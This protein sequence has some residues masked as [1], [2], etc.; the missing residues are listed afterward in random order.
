MQIKCSNSPCNNI[1]K[2]NKWEYNNKYLFGIVACS[3]CRKSESF[4]Q[5]KHDKYVEH[6]GYPPNFK[7]LEDYL[8][9]L[10]K[11]PTCQNDFFAKAKINKFCS[12][13]CAQSSPE[14]NENKK[15]TYEKNYGVEHNMKSEKGQEEYKDGMI[16]KYGVEYPL[17]SESVKKKTEQT[18]KQRHGVSYPLQNKDILAKMKQTNVAKYGV[19][20]PSYSHDIINK[21]LLS[22]YGKEIPSNN[23]KRLNDREWLKKELETKTQKEVSEN[24]GVSQPIISRKAMEF[25]IEIK[26]KNTSSFEREIYKFLSEE[27]DIENVILN[28]NKIISPF[29]LDIYLSDYNLAIEFNGVYW[30][31]EKNGKDKNYHLNKTKLCEDKDIQLLH[32]FENEW[33]EK[34]NIWKSIIRNKINANDN[35]IF[36]RKCIV[37]EVDSKIANLFL[38]GNHLQGVDSS[39]VR[40]GLYYEDELV[41]LFTV[42]KSRYNKKYQYEIHRFCNKLDNSVVGGFGKLFKHFERTYKPESLITYADKRFSNGNLYNKFFDYSHDSKP[43]YFYVID[44]ILHSRLQFQKHK[45]ADKLDLFDESLSEYQNML[46]NGYD[47]IWDC[48]NKVYIL[49]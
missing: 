8:S 25:G 21:I 1:F 48:G 30:H 44:S 11:C 10:K 16:K 22:K 42:G 38:D 6:R 26:H 13:S 23:L 9:R 32:I 46:M 4:K 29:E 31:S 40:L 33:K 14:T 47:R 43:N 28:T 17:Q 37:K 49:K 36:A 20:N 35:K 2:I 19:E 18:N 12:V 3:S 27:L 15:K 41:S 24:L 34:Q 7:S 39:S 45:L 5:F